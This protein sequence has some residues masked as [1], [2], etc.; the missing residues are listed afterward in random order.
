MKK[1]STI[2]AIGLSMGFANGLSATA[3]ANETITMNAVNDKG[4]AEAVGE[5]EVSESQYGLVFEPALKDMAPGMHGFHMHANASCEPGKKEGKMA[6]AVSAGGHFDPKN[7]QA[8]G[9]PWGEGHLGDLP[10]LYVTQAGEVD[11]PVLAPRLTMK[12]LKGHAFIVH[13]DGDNFA[14]Q[15]KKLGGGGARVACGLFK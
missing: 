3:V 13:A 12:D 10:P 1:L 2:L 11:Q 7:T 9:E 6:A 15:P 4:V 14:D 5:I 8:H